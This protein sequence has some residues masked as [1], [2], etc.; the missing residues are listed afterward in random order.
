MV[1]RDRD[2]EAIATDLGTSVA[3]AAA[4]QWGDL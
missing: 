4:V 3:T 1:H 2:F